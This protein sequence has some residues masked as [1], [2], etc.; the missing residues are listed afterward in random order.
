MVKKLYS[1]TDWNYHKGKLVWDDL[2]DENGYTIITICTVALA[3]EECATFFEDMLLSGNNP[4]FIL[5]ED[6]I[7]DIYQD[8]ESFTVQDI[9]Y[10][11]DLLGKITSIKYQFIN[12]VPPGWEG[13]A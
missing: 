11:L 2:L 9:Q 3:K 10:V 1:M 7:W 13:V 6:D 4:I 8:I 5:G 12:D